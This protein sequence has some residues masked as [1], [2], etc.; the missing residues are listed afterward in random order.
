MPPLF[1]L[2]LSINNII[3]LSPKPKWALDI[4]Y[5]LDKGGVGWGGDGADIGMTLWLIGDGTSSSP[6]PAWFWSSARLLNLSEACVDVEATPTLCSRLGCKLVYIYL[7]ASPIE[8][9]SMQAFILK[10]GAGPWDHKFWPLTKPAKTWE[11]LAQ[12]L[13]NCAW[14]HTHWLLHSLFFPVPWANIRWLKE[15]DYIEGGRISNVLVPNCE[16]LYQAIISNNQYCL[17]SNNPAQD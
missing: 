8:P 16:L 5:G 13:P 6:G 17:I 15:M 1:K 9:S 10:K 12:T 4:S 3:V 14:Q 11:P 7:G 2:I